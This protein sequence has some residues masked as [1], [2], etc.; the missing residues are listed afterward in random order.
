MQRALARSLGRETTTQPA[1]MSVPAAQAASLTMPPTDAYNNYCTYPGMFKS[2]TNF[3]I[4][5]FEELYQMLD[6][7]H[8]PQPS[9]HGR[10][11]YNIS[12]SDLVETLSLLKHGNRLSQVVAEVGGSLSTADR[13]I[14]ATIKALVVATSSSM[15]WPDTAQRQQLMGGLWAW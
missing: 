2:L 15:Q 1:D 12:K 8:A 14:W 3:T 13:H 6:H 7:T 9:Q 5:E 4:E 10:P 11:A